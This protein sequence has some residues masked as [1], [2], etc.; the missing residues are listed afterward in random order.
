M[1]PESPVPVEQ[2]TSLQWKLDMAMATL[3]RARSDQNDRNG[4]GWFLGIVSTVLI[5]GGSLFTVCSCTPLW[6]LWGFA[7]IGIALLLLMKSASLF[8]ERVAEQDEADRQICEVAMYLESDE[9]KQLS[10]NAWY[11]D[12]LHKLILTAE[13]RLAVAIFKILSIV[14]DNRSL[15]LAQSLT[16]SRGGVIVFTSGHDSNVRKAAKEASTLL[17]RRFEM[18]RK[19]ENL[20]RAA[21]S[22]SKMELLRPSDSSGNIL[23]DRLLRAESRPEATETEGN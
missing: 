5:L 2:A 3:D 12:Q 14:G 13:P 20:L 22:P 16:M 8:H 10:M 4:V 6:A 19:G 9:A 1:E 11:R 15:E 18:A 21:D 17:T 23:P 7:G